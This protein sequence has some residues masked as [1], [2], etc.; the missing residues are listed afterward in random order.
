MSAAIDTS[1]ETGIPSERFLGHGGEL[2]PLQNLG[3]R[4]PPMLVIHG[5]QDTAVPYARAL[6][7]RRALRE[8]ATWPKSPPRPESDTALPARKEPAGEPRRPG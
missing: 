7:L 1:E 4:M 8:T 3:C 5:D 2:S 6:A